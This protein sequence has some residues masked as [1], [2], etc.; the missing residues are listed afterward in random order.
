MF[1]SHLFSEFYFGYVW[2][3]KRMFLAACSSSVHFMVEKEEMSTLSKTRKHLKNGWQWR[4]V[5]L[6]SAT[7]SSLFIPSTF[8]FFTLHFSIVCLRPVN[9]VTVYS[10]ITF[11]FCIYP[12]ISCVCDW[13]VLRPSEMWLW[14]CE[15]M[16]LGIWKPC[17][18][19]VLFTVPSV[20][21]SPSLKNF[22]RKGG[23]ASFCTRHIPSVSWSL[24]QWDG[25]TLNVRQ[26]SIAVLTT[27]V[28]INE[29]LLS[30]LLWHCVD[31]VIWN[32]CLFSFCMFFTM[33]K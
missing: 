23:K 29:L 18:H 19:S 1:I 14:A 21:C 28:S 27:A 22:K 33:L 30:V 13:E 8:I 16:P 25:E 10:L 4:I 17:Y 31:F 32:K 2:E 7:I 20:V 9:N 11:V 6:I 12:S 15:G 5:S 3:L 24:I 26:A